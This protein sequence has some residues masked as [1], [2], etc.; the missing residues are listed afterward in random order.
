MTLEHYEVRSKVGVG[1]YASVY[2]V[3]NVDSDH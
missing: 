3:H 1:K 2:R